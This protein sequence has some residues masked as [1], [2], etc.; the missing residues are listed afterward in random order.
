MYARRVVY[1]GRESG[2]DDDVC[3]KRSKEGSRG[4]RSRWFVLCVRHIDVPDLSD[5]RLVK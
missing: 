1:I 2:R 5:Y 4:W 3:H